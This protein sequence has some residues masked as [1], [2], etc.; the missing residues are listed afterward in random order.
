MLTRLAGSQKRDH[1]GAA[2][3]IREGLE[4]TLTVQRL[5]L[6]GALERTLR[7][8]NIIENLMGASRATRGGSNG[9]AAV[10]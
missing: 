7:T 8:T 5:S 10:R 2:A 6:T 3:S 9:G 1:P 4:E